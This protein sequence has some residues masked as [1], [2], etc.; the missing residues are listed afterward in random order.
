MESAIRD[1][2]SL[3]TLAELLN[4]YSLREF[5]PRNIETERRGWRQKEIRWNVGES[6]TIRYAVLRV[7]NRIYMYMYMY[8]YAIS[9]CSL[10]TRVCTFRHR[11]RHTYTRARV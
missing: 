3:V 4:L 10:H 6:A 1:L 5:V 11:H 7:S 9:C 8:M 2:D